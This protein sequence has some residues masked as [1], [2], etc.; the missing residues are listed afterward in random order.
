MKMFKCL[1]PNTSIIEE[2]SDK[3]K[4]KC[5]APKTSIPRG[6]SKEPRSTFKLRFTLKKRKPPT[7]KHEIIPK[8]ILKVQHFA[9]GRSLPVEEGPKKRQVRVRFDLGNEKQDTNV[10][11]SISTIYDSDISFDKSCS[12]I[13]D[14]DISFDK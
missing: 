6:K 7:K 13:Y 9:G 10:D 1:A 4:F 5:L 8:S 14:S 3:C 12:I 11:L 2:T